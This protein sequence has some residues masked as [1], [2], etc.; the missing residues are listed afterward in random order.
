MIMANLALLLAQS[1]R[2][3]TLIDLDI[4][5]AD[6]HILYGLFNPRNTLTDFITRN[7]DNIQDVAHTFYAYH[8]LQLIPGTGDTLQTA[9]MNFQEKLRLLRAIDDIDT[10]I[11][12]LDVGAGTSY[13]AST[14]R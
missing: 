4:G 3:V 13:H 8:G 11:V 12:L 7:V 9:N 5:G 6:A 1:G 14:L 10:D 2:R